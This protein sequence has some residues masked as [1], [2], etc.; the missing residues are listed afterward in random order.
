MFVSHGE[1]DLELAQEIVK[2][3]ETHELSCL[4]GD[5]DF[6]PG[7]IKS[8]VIAEAVQSSRRVVLLLSHKSLQTGW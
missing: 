7:T 8:E 4:L 5:R 6:L 3:I 1:S 2:Q